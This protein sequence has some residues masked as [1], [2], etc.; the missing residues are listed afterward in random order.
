MT[1][2]EVQPAD[3]I[4]SEKCEARRKYGDAVLTG[5]VQEVER[6]AVRI[7]GLWFYSDSWTFHVDRPAEVLEPREGRWARHRGTGAL[8]RADGTTWRYTN[9]VAAFYRI[10]AD[11]WEPVRIVPEDGA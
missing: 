7:G 10:T 3:L 9:G 5:T 4:E 8:V 1:M 6:R 2:R 11:E